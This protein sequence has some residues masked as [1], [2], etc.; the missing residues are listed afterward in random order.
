MVIGCTHLRDAVWTGN[1]KVL[2]SKPKE[3]TGMKHLDID[4]SQVLDFFHVHD[5][6]H[7]ARIIN[8][9]GVIK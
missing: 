6:I 1:W 7:S 9:P 8:I 5:F 2:K 4:V 3:K